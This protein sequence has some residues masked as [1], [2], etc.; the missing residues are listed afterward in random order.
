MYRSFLILIILFALIWSVDADMLVLKNGLSLEGK[1]K[2]GSE[3]TIKFETSGAV[4]K[5]AISEIKSLAF[6]EPE[7]PAT[8]PAAAAAVVTTGAASGT[9]IPA[10][11]VVEVSIKQTITVP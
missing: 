3:T 6:S 4:Q 9:Q 1:F 2:G 5:V 10:G 7:P 8:P 11:S